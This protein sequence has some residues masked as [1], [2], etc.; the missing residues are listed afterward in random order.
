M[1]QP[2]CLDRLADGQRPRW[3]RVI[4]NRASYPAEYR[5]FLDLY[6]QGD[7]WEAHEALEDLWRRTRDPIRRSYYQGVIQVAAACVHADRGN[8]RGVVKLLTKAD[9]RLGACP[10]GYLDI[11]VAGLRLTMSLWR[12]AAEAVLSG[13]SST[14][15]LA[16]KPAIGAA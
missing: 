4:D 12:K 9:S 10:E 13:E 7:H 16:G 5:V 6:R 1:I 3:R 14:L 11:D 2:T 15:D 8:M